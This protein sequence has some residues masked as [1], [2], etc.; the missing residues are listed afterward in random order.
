VV[1]AEIKARESTVRI[2]QCI[3]NKGCSV[4]DLEEIGAGMVYID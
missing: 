2:D 4:E 3:L 1:D